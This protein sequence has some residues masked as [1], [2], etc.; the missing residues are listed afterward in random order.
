MIIHFFKTS[1]LS[2]HNLITFNQLHIAE[3]K[4]ITG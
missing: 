2:A 3:A 1:K 4:E